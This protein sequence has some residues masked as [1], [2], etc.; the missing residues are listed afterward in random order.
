[1]K[2]VEMPEER[3]GFDEAADRVVE[4]PL[5]ERPRVAVGGVDRGDAVLLQGGAHVDELVPRRRDGQ[6]VL[7]EDL[8]VVDHAGGRERV[9][10]HAR[11]ALVGG[12][13]LAERPDARTDPVGRRQGAEVPQHAALDVPG[14][15]EV[16]VEAADVRRL[17]AHELRGDRRGA[18]VHDAD[19]GVLTFEPSEELVEVG[20][21]LLL[22]LV[23][24]DR[25]RA[26]RGRTTGS[27]APGER[28]RAEGNAARCAGEEAA[29]TECASGDAC[30]A[31]HCCSLSR[32]VARDHLYSAVNRMSTL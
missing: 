13:L 30:P 23:E 1:L 8:L 17:P 12:V 10:Q 26:A 6:V 15:L 16:V 28:H 21:D 22:L 19:A 29:A 25:R 31:D 18:V 20:D 3:A 4:E 5:P 27:R 7:G 14:E 11:L 24:A 32:V 2:N 9:R